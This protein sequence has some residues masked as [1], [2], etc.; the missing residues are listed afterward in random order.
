MGNRRLL[1]DETF[2]D[3]VDEVEADDGGIHTPMAAADGST[4]V[5]FTNPLSVLLLPPLLLVL[6]DPSALSPPRTKTRLSTHLQRA[7]RSCN[8]PSSA[9]VPSSSFFFVAVTRSIAGRGPS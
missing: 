3:V 6:P 5:V 1:A 8:L 9:A 7:F 4:A 2:D